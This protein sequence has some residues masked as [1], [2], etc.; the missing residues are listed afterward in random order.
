MRDA[1]RQRL[2]AE[3]SL[4]ARTHPADLGL[5]LAEGMSTVRRRIIR[6]WVV[7]AVVSVA[8]MA[9]FVAA[10]FAAPDDEGGPGPV[11]LQSITVTASSQLLRP[12]TKLDLT[13]RGTYSND[14]TKELVDG[15]TWTSDKPEVAAVSPIGEV[16]AATA[17]TV[18]ITAMHSDV[19]GMLNLTVTDGPGLLTGLRIK[20]DQTTV[21]LGGTTQLIAEGTFSD[22]SIGNRNEPAIW[23]SRN[24]G[25]ATVDGL[26][27]VTGMNP[28]VA[29]ISATEGTIQATAAITVTDPGTPNPTVVPNG[30]VVDPATLRVKHTQ[31]QPLTAFITATDGT[32]VPPTTVKWSSTDSK[33]AN[34][35]TSGSVTGTGP[36]STRITALCVDANGKEW[37]ATASVTVE[38]VA[39]SITIGPAGPHRLTPQQ[40]IQ[41]AATVTFSDGSTST[42]AA[43][44]WNASSSPPLV[45]IVSRSGVVTGVRNGR[46][47]VTA[48]LDGATS[49]PIT[50]DVAIAFP[51]EGEIG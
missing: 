24:P 15:L 48:S 25:I 19:K 29:T 51:D 36:G 41:L 18:V 12:D 47:N 7:A 11:T 40:S 8:L 42:K 44:S 49:N 37:Q 31:T 33:I 16:T 4:H 38:P 39:R 43:V 20:P 34:V 13:A 28:G 46:A 10:V 45:V 50:V 32:R 6:A 30:C 3:A 26:G 2:L 21:S 35:N 1:L 27:M 22:N 23:E 14:E 17:G 5:A 9:A